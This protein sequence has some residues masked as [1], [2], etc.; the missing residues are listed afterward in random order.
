MMRVTTAAWPIP[1]TIHY[2]GDVS[3]EEADDYIAKGVEILGTQRVE[4]GKNEHL[5]LD[6]NGPEVINPFRQIKKTEEYVPNYKSRLV[7]RGDQ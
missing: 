7:A 3:P 1:P 4:T 5:K 6:Q 2:S